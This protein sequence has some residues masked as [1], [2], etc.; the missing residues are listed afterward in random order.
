M[1]SNPESTSSSLPIWWEPGQHCHR[2][3]EGGNYSSELLN[4]IAKPCR[5]GPGCSGI[6]TQKSRPGMQPFLPFQRPELTLWSL[7]GT[8]PSQVWLQGFRVSMLCCQKGPL[9]VSPIG[10]TC[11]QKPGCRF[12]KGAWFILQWKLWAWH[13]RT[14]ALP[15]LLQAPQP[16]E[17]LTCS[18]PL[19]Q[20]CHQSPGGRD[21]LLTQRRPAGFRW[22][23]ATVANLRATMAQ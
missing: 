19:P 17:A 18:A 21:T 13:L 8:S 4:H 6:R 5:L 1:L 11:G 12:L 9:F 22:V 2:L 14:A 16:K 3:A 10:G 23:G 7:E 15:F 20:R